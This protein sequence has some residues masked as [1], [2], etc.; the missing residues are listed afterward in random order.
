[1][2]A[3]GTPGRNDVLNNAPMCAYS[4]KS[5]HLGLLLTAARHNGLEFFGPGKVA[6]NIQSTTVAGHSA[7]RNHPDDAPPGSDF[8]TVTVGVRPGQALDVLYRE[9]AS[10]QEHGQQELCSRAKRAASA[11]IG[12]LRSR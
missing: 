8:C 4:S 6:G 1:M 9:A 2:P 11:A 7:Y 10:E 3:K 5:E 12:T